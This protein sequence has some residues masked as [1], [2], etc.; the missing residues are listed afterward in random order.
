MAYGD[1][2]DPLVAAMLRGR[3]GRSNSIGFGGGSILSAPPEQRMRQLYAQ[4]LLGADP[5]SAKTKGEGVARLGQ[6]LLGA[7]LAREDMDEAKAE[8]QGDSAL[9]A[10]A[11]RSQDRTPTSFTNDAGEKETIAWN[12]PDPL[13]M[14][15]ILG[16]GSPRLQEAG[17]E[18]SLAQQQRAADQAQKTVTMLS[19]DEVKAAGLP[20][21]AYQK[22]PY[23]KINLIAKAPLFGMPSDVGASAS[24]PA[25]GTQTVPRSAPA[26]P[27][28]LSDIPLSPQA[29]ATIGVESGGNVNAASSTSSATGP[30]QFIDST[31]INM[32]QKNAPGLIQG[33]SRE[34]ILAMRSDPEVSG[35]MVDAYAKENASVLAGAGI[36]ATPE[37]LHFAHTFG[38]GGAVKMLS[39][40][41]RAAAANLSSRAAVEANRPLFFE[42]NGRPRTVAELRQTLGDRFNQNMP[43]ETAGNMPV[44]QPP[45][46]GAPM[47][48]LTPP[49]TAD[50]MPNPAAAS[51]GVQVAQASTGTMTDAAPAGA[52][53][54]SNQQY[55]RPQNPE[56]GQ[57]LDF[58]LPVDAN[59]R[60]PMLPDGRIDISRARPY[61]KPSYSTV[62]MGTSMGVI[63]GNTGEVVRTLPKDIAGEAAARKSG[64]TQAQRQIDAPKAVQQADL[65]LSSIDGTLNHPGF[66]WGTGKSSWTTYVPGTPAYDFGKRV[67]QLQGQAFLQAFESLKG[68]GAISEMEGKKAQA[69]IARLDNSQT[70]EG[71]R[72]AL[73]ELRGIVTA[74]RERAIAQGGG[75]QSATAPP[76]PTPGEPRVLRFDAQGNLIQ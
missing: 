19:A 61:Q 32:M 33:K 11:L 53:A 46:S 20:P 26:G 63:D 2:I 73:G 70:E 54:A 75:A 52:S 24:P 23:G 29:R 60:L 47:P 27:G 14:A 30:A 51:R 25:S 67:E 31:W 56:T 8:R 38:G 37:N 15:T 45:T 28:P 44:M 41:P 57:F 71:F 21:G 58:E 55:R 49:G 13:T 59:G 1:Q 17:L 65:V 36:E 48:A 5:A 18:L 3:D 10:A 4:Q 72:D 34:E 16:Q 22:D 64:E 35:A 76:Q 43:Q 7:Y 12:K 9:I 66:E 74:A 39:A 40:D 50:A 6:Q 62:D 68:G 69:A 42:K